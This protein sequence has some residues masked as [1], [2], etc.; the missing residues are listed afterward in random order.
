MLLNEGK[1]TMSKQVNSTNSV[2]NVE[3]VNSNVYCVMF[4]TLRRGAYNTV[5]N[6]Q[7]DIL[8]WNSQEAADLFVQARNKR[9]NVV[10]CYFTSTICTTQLHTNF[11]Q[12]KQ[13]FDALK[14]LVQ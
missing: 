4:Y 6:K 9:G 5:N 1:C 7:G 13:N 10:M 14:P 11:T 3:N 2:N 12:Y 8:L